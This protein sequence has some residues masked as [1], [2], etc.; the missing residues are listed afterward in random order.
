MGQGKFQQIVN[1]SNIYWEKNITNVVAPSKGKEVSLEDNGRLISHE[2]KEC[3][4]FWVLVW[5]TSKPNLVLPG[6]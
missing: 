4:E 1:K 2:Q 3:F 6:S 5:E